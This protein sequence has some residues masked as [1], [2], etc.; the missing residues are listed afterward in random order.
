[1]NDNQI[2]QSA[3]LARF[4]FRDDEIEEFE[5]ISKKIHLLTCWIEISIAFLAG[6]QLFRS[7]NSEIDDRERQDDRIV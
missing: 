5:I 1:M 3:D 7:K 4:I 2:S 6:L